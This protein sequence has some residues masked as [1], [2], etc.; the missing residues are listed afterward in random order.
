MRTAKIERKTTTICVLK[1][2][3]KELNQMRDAGEHF[4]QVIRRLLKSYVGSGEAVI[5]A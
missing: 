3:W 5:N 4:D 2:T 1:D